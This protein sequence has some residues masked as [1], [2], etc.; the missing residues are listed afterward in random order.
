MLI[1]G[2]RFWIIVPLLG[3]AVHSGLW[4]VR[5]LQPSEWFFYGACVGTFVAAV[6]LIAENAYG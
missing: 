1:K 2:A 4:L 5:G 6:S 3:I